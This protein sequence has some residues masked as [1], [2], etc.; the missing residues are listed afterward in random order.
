L[1][2]SSPNTRTKYDK[3]KVTPIKDIFWAKG[4]PTSD[5]YFP[6]LPDMPTAADADEKKPAKVIPT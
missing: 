2:T 3:T 6:N 4:T 1:G 5:R